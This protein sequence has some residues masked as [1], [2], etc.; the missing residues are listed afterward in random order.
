MVDKLLSDEDELT[1]E[2][3]FELKDP[4]VLSYLR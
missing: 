3:A 2:D 1:P 4:A